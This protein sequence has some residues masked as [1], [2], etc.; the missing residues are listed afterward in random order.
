MLLYSIP[1][2]LKMSSAMTVCA[3]RFVQEVPIELT[4]NEVMSAA[5]SRYCC[6]FFCKLGHAALKRTSLSLTYSYHHPSINHPSTKYS[7]Q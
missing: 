7:V 5:V 3:V 2:F 1:E 6:R 4:V